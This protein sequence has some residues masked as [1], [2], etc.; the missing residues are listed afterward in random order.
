MI[1][2]TGASGFLGQHLVQRLSVS[3]KSVRA[4]YNHTTPSKELLNLAG[5]TWQQCD[6]LDIFETEQAFIG[7]TE[8]YHCAAIVSFDPARKEEVLNQNIESTANV[9]N[10]A[11][12]QGIRK[13]IYVSSIASLGRSETETKLITEEAEWEE[14]NRNSVYGLSKYYAE[15]E[16][17]RGI[18]E[19]LEAVIINPGIILG[20][21][22]WDKGS[23][24]LMRVVNDEFPYYTEG[25][26]GF[27][28]VQD[29]V[30]IMTILM[31]ASIASERFIVCSGNYP[32][33]DVFTQMA[34]NLGKK[35]PHIRATSFMT[36]FIWRW[37]LLKNKLSGTEPT[38]TKETVRNAQSRCYYD[39]S[40]LLK[41][42][43]D[44]NYRPIS[45]TI[46]DMS[47]AFLKK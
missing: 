32:Y 9:V 38:I 26:N 4:L 45:E 1:L 41:I 44:F 10:A 17:W 33:R 46:A 25:V 18:G 28:D 36:G 42:L 43:P 11:L 6:L 22:N 39:N 15:M 34:N 20:A 35:P 31:D 5:V 3:G 47:A 40:K 19:G 23:A 16:V 27:V 2:V 30:S 37:S 7:I 14:S 8:V 12:E 24:K 21:G 29:V 13:L